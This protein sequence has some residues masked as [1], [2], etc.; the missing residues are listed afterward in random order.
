MVLPLSSQVSP[1]TTDRAAV[2]SER[3]PIAIPLSSVALQE[4]PITTLA[5]PAALTSPI[6][7]EAYPALALAP[8]AVA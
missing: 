1:I 8:T 4:C 5:V 7:T 6:A 2:A 3:Y